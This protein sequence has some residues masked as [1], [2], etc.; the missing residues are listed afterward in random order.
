MGEIV[1]YQ[2]IICV[3][4][5]AD[6]TSFDVVAKLRGICKQKKIG[7]G[8]TLDPMATGVLPVFLGRCTRACDIVPIQDKAY[9]ATVRLGVVTDTQDT[10]GRVLEEHPAQ[11]TREKL[12]AVL[13][14]F[15]GEILQLPPMYSAIKVNGVRLYKLARQGNEVERPSRPVTIHSLELEEFDPQAQTFAISVHCSKGTYI[16]TLCHDIG[17][18]LGCG[19]AM[20]TLVRTRAMGFSL[21]EC[22][23]FPQIQQAADEGRL[24]ELLQPVERVFLTYPAL[25][26]SADQTRMLL[27]GVRLD[28]NRLPPIQGETVRVQSH[29][30]RFLGLART[31]RETQEL[32]V[33]K[34][35]AGDEER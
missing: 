28:L 15:R 34:L 23:T 4:K 30:G 26:L 29:T 14:R 16:R 6:F 17:Q 35:L 3:H 18:A 2:G 21:E 11:V 7:H 27:N 8:G 20:D 22:C 32:V 10:T 9:R 13:P 31:D 1:L 12:E 24:E 5:P 25:R 33:T 19:A